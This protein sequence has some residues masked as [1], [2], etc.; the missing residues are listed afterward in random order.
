MPHPCH[1][2]RHITPQC[3]KDQ[4]C[5]LQ[6]ASEFRASSNLPAT[7]FLQKLERKRSRRERRLFGSDRVQVPFGNVQLL[8]GTCH[9]K[10]KR[11]QG[12][13]VPSRRLELIR[14]LCKNSREPRD[15]AWQ[16]QE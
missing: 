7:Y 13:F 11:M 10:H 16:K 9:L 12:Y 6:P 15:T 8:V 2:P 4:L 14:L 5:L 3:S 1:R